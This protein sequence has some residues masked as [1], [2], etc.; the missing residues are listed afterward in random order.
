MGLFALS[1][2]AIVVAVTL[3]LVTP[4][5]LPA[6]DVSVTTATPEEI[7]AA[8][9]EIAIAVA[10]LVFLAALLL[11]LRMDGGRAAIERDAYIVGEAATAVWRVVLKPLFV[12]WSLIEL[13]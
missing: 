7:A 10:G 11:S 6:L 2:M 3:R 5:I 12:L 4:A 13:A 1:G 9:L 8:S